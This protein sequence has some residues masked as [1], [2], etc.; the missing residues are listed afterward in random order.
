V[1]D[2]AEHIPYCQWTGAIGGQAMNSESC[3][4]M[5]KERGLQ[6]PER[7]PSFSPAVARFREG[8]PGCRFLSTHH[9]RAQRGERSE[10][11]RALDHS[12]IVIYIALFASTTLIFPRQKFL[13]RHFYATRKNPAPTTNHYFIFTISAPC[14]ATVM[15]NS[16]ANFPR[17]FCRHKSRT[18][19]SP[20]NFRSDHFAVTFAGSEPML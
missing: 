17:S 16:S 9:F 1:K 18:A 12:R 6:N 3:V 10:Y 14:G 20:D 19:C 5:G 11:L 13:P 2:I 8:Y 4:L 7:I 15:E